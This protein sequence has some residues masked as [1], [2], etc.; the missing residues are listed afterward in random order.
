ASISRFSEKLQQKEV[1]AQLKA[2]KIDIIIGTHRLLQESVAFHDLGLLIIDEEHRFGV[3]HKEKIKSKKKEVDILTLTATPIPRT[4]N[5]AMSGIWDMSVI[6]TPP[7]GRLAVK[8]FVQRYEDGLI[9]EA[10]L[11]ESL[12]SGQIYYVHN[13]VE[14]IE[15]AAD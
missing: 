1:I 9:K 3:S 2:G 6:A 11:R 8:T 10:I 7:A 13:R 5:M 4:L 12:R 15:R 14:S